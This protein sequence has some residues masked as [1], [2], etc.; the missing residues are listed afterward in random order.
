M[1]FVALKPP[2]GQRLFGSHWSLVEILMQLI[3]AGYLKSN[4]WLIDFFCWFCC[5][6]ATSRAKGRLGHIYFLLVGCW[7]EIDFSDWFGWIFIISKMASLDITKMWRDPGAP[8][9]SFYQ[10]RPECTDVPKSKFRIKVRISLCS[11]LSDVVWFGM[12]Y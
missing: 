3:G 2:A 1:V 6:E 12:R 11:N 10:V 5:F 9:D 8:A 4:F 7:V